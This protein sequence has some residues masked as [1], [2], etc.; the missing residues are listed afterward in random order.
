LQNENVD[1][2]DYGLP[3]PDFYTNH[4]RTNLLSLLKTCRQVYVMP[5]EL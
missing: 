3:M 1:D 2:P 5:T 4:P